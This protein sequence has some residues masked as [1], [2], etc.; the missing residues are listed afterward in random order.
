MLLCLFITIGITMH[1]NASHNTLCCHPLPQSCSL[2]TALLSITALAA[3]ALAIYA[4][5]Y[6]TRTRQ[7][8]RSTLCI[9]WSSS[10]PTAFTLD[11][12]AICQ[13]NKKPPLS[14]IKPVA[15][16]P[17][18]PVASR[19]INKPIVPV[20]NGQEEDEEGLD[21]SSLPNECIQLY[22]AIPDLYPKNAPLAQAK[23][24]ALKEFNENCR[25]FKISAEK[26]FA[27]FEL[28]VDSEKWDKVMQRL[29]E[30]FVQA[31]DKFTRKQ[32]RFIKSI[33]P[34]NSTLREKPV[35]ITIPT[36]QVL[37]RNFPTR[38]NLQLYSKKLPPILTKLENI[39][40][41]SA[42][43]TNQ[44]SKRDNHEF[45]VT[46]LTEFDAILTDPL[47]TNISIKKNLIHYY[48]NIY[49]YLYSFGASISVTDKYSDGT[50]YVRKVNALAEA[51]HHKLGI[52]RAYVPICR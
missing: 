23:T 5:I 1:L 33:K 9:C 29:E 37:T 36:I 27:N 15:D 31:Q 11:A 19:A 35:Q 6:L 34:G 45:V 46:S 26:Y 51:I 40:A 50:S 28:P 43:Q 3:S 13:I 10:I 17:N 24:R 42:M 32:R 25:Q 14:P 44:L 12:L 47:A 4:V 8:N 52:P 48:V 16:V 2:G 21:Q 20:V 38:A 18:K 22:D 30:A 7:W 49:E 39:C 41:W